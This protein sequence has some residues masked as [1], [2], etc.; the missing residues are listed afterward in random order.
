MKLS[1]LL[2][3][4]V[5][6]ETDSDV[7]GLV[8]DSRK[9]QT[10]NAFIALRGANQHGMDHA[11]QAIANGAKAVIYDPAG[12]DVELSLPPEVVKVGVPELGTQLGAIAA[13]F[14]DHPSRQLAL[15]G[16]TGTNGKTTSSQLIA[17]ALPDCGVIGTLGWGEPGHLSSTLN[18]TPD[19]LAIQGMLRQFVQRKKHAVAMEV[20]SHGLQQGRVNA[21]EFAGA[22][23]TNLS[24]DH[25]DY[26][27]SMEG[28]LQAKLGLF[29]NPA[30][31]FAVINLDDPASA[32]VLKRL[33]HGV[34]RWTFS[35]KGNSVAGA[36][37][38]IAENIRHGADGIRFD[39]VWGERKSH[40]FTPLVGAFNL[41]N[42]L[43]VLGVLL[44]MD[45]PFSEAIARLTELKAIVGRMEKFG[46]QD[47]PTV[48]V[49]YAHTPDALEK[50]L[51]A[52][53]GEGRLWVVFGC[54]GNRDKGKRPEMGR[55]AEIWADS[56]IVTDDNPRGEPPTEIIKDILAGCQKQNVTV[57]NDRTTAISTVIQHAAKRDCV[58]IAGKGH[59]NYQEIN[60]I[61]MPFSD[62]DVVNQTLA[63]W[64][65]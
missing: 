37:S 17:Q 33:K 35:T 61:R 46:G 55:I 11:R 43:A 6:I 2:K 20:S 41:E 59:E 3:G 54:G 56:V 38:L 36:E 15:I 16:I 27:G 47:K 5:E 4:L 52:A 40:A 1:D 64:S 49:D 50:V 22:V 12:L 19:A 8:L 58:M 32:E 26:H 65:E 57:I 62:R 42:V 31:E 7:N 14:Y 25:L 13:G 21:V 51:K 34:R 9:V 30:L 10:G 53:R 28:Y 24:R 18:T 48:F 39:V 60:G 63:A 44:A 23:F 29:A 45:M